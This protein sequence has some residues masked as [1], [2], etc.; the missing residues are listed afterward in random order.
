M[1]VSHNCALSVS[2]KMTIWLCNDI[3]SFI[4]IS[5]LMWIFCLYMFLQIYIVLLYACVFNL[6]KWYCIINLILFLLFV[7]KS[8]LLQLI[9]ISSDCCIICSGDISYILPV[10][11]LNNNLPCYFPLPYSTNNTALNILVHLLWNLLFM[12]MHTQELN[13]WIN[14]I[15]TY[16]IWLSGGECSLDWLSHLTVLLA[17]EV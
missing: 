16:I 8:M 12:G 14:K 11:S 2:T 3:P 1:L 10:H 7:P 13:S 15:C 9:Y 17:W 6:C 4:L 5:N